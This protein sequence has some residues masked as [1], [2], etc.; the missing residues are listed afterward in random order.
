M[1]AKS[2]LPLIRWTK[3]LESLRTLSL[4]QPWA[5]LVVNGYKDFE[6]RSDIDRAAIAGQHSAVSQ[7]SALANQLKRSDGA[8]LNNRKRCVNL[9]G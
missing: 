7:Q 4:R 3:Q 5:W 8:C 2:K 1:S 9:T 6:N